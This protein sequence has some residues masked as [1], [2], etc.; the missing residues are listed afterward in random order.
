MPQLPG[1]PV[2]DYVRDR[3]EQKVSKFLRDRDA[4]PKQL[5]FQN[6]TIEGIDYIEP[7]RNGIRF[8]LNNNYTILPGGEIKK[9]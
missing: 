8:F 2:S 7:I 9:L 6:S 5:D 4:K 3:E 1:L